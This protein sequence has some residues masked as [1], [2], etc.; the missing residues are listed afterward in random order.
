MENI[1]GA[2]FAASDKDSGTKRKKKRLKF[3][4]QDELG[5]KHQK[6]ESKLYCYLHDEKTSHTTR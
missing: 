3:K 4:G 2:K 6:R 1:A 5:K